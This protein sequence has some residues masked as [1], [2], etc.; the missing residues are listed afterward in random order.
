M[1][2]TES[3]PTAAPAAVPHSGP[4]PLLISEWRT[5]QESGAPGSGLP[6]LLALLDAEIKAASNTWIALATPEQIRSQWARV[7]QLRDEGVDLPLYG[8]PF[9]AK[10]N[11]DAIGFPTTAGCPAFAGP[12][13][14]TDATVI[15][16]LKAAGAVLLGK[17]NLDQFATGLVGTRSPY[18]A[19]ANSFDPSRVSGGSSSGS[20]IVVARG[21]VPLS[22]GT[23]TA[24]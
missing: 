19:V 9:A 20:A 4:F 23:D 13:A 2:A 8:V 10:D 11:I 14:T 17:T 7:T 1:T 18:G 16:R 12:S 21:V 15:A 6:C 22:L 5:Y 24:G 3:K